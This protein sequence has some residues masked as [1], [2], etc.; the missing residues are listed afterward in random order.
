MQRIKSGCGYL[1]V[2]IV[3]FLN[4]VYACNVSNFSLE[5]FGNGVVNI[6]EKYRHS[7][8]DVVDD[9]IYIDNR[10]TDFQAYFRKCLSPNISE[11]W[12]QQATHS[13]LHQLL[14]LLKTTSFYTMS[15]EVNALYAKV[16]EVVK[17]KGLAVEPY[18]DDLHRGYVRAGEFENA[19]ALERDFP[20]AVFSELPE[21]RRMPVVGRSV[22]KLD[23]TH[24]FVKQQPFSFPQDGYIVVISSPICNPC[25][26]LLNWL[27]TDEPELGRLFSK[28]SSWVFSQNGK[29]YW[30]A[31]KAINETYGF[32][33]MSYAVS[34]ADW[35][36][37]THWVTPTLLFFKDG[38]LKARFAGWPQEGRAKELKNALK[39]IGLM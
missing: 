38:E 14:S 16:L 10:T 25:K 12:L 18:L 22:F 35:P 29:M 39:I 27:K 34:R 21:I 5:Q 32:M 30:S 37:V 20:H 11:Q 13:Q 24:R 17:S 15:S 33:N 4:N 23:Q 28:H 1:V 36:E 8:A 6:K 19:L 3:F 2:S 31:L 7:V 9:A 26:R